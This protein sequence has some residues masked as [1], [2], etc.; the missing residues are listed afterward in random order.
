MLGQGNLSVTLSA[1]IIL[2]LLACEALGAKV[3]IGGGAVE[4]PDSLILSMILSLII[5]SLTDSVGVGVAGGG[6]GVMVGGGGSERL[7]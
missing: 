6:G 2:A 7:S 5:L 1:T 3:R 4:R